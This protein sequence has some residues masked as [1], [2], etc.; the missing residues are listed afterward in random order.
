MRTA[1]QSTSAGRRTSE[2]GGVL[3]TPLRSIDQPKDARRQNVIVSLI[4][5]LGL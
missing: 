1:M 2:A 5:S 4:G 3:W